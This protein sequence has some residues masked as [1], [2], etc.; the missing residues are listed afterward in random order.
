[1]IFIQQKQVALKIFHKLKIRRNKVVQN[2]SMEM[3]RAVEDS[4][5]PEFSYNRSSKTSL[6]DVV[7]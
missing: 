7:R 1:M 5:L 4:H 2:N 6:T 3:V